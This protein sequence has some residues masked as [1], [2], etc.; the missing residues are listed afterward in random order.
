M[1]SV[2]KY[3]IPIA[4]AVLAWGF[5]VSPYFKE[6]SFGV[7]LFLFGML[8]LEDGFRSFTGGVLE[9]LL[10]KTTS[11]QWKC[12]AFGAVS[13][14]LMQ[15]S[16]LVSVVTMSFL[17]S[18]LLGLAQGMGITLGANIG[19]TT[20][21]WI[22]ASLGMKMNI[23]ALAMPLTIFGIILIIQPGKN[24]KGIGHIL[25]GLG[26][27][28]L[29]MHHIKAGFS[30]FGDKVSL[31]GY[32]MSGFSGLITYVALG[33]AATVLLQSSHASLVIIMAA[34]SAGQ[35]TFENGA[36][37]V[38]GANIGTT[39]TA[40]LGAVGANEQGKRLAAAHVSFNL[41]TALAVIILMPGV[42]FL[43]GELSSVIGIG[44]RDYAMR[45]ALFHT[46]FNFL[47]VIAMTPL[48]G[49]FERL[50]TGWIKTPERGVAKPRYLSLA[51]VDFPDTAVEAVRRE[52][53]SMYDDAVEII[54][55][56]IGF[57][58]SEVLSGADLDGL[59]KA[60]PSVPEYEIDEAYRSRIKEIF[61]AVIEFISKAA[62]SWRESQ[63]QRLFW[64]RDAGRHV[65][66]AVKAAK[67]LQKN[68][69]PYSSSPNAR[70][71]EAYMRLRLE[72]ASMIRELENLRNDEDR[73][74]LLLSLDHLKVTVAEL[75]HKLLDAVYAAINDGS[76]TP[77]MGTSLINDHDYA[78]E[79]IRHLVDAAGTLFMDAGQD[80]TAAQRQVALDRGEIRRMAVDGG[81]AENE[82]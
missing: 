66:E 23:A 82:D 14:T 26:F 49:R 7:A 21:G 27:F 24:Q 63:S 50:L 8:A 52:L 72:V 81:K 55:E 4:F 74:V 60:R 32:A 17:S 28:F 39:S 29:G 22:I 46:V 12:I 43:V 80:M 42:L 36:A 48:I 1:H 16:G 40:I 56:V 67:H 73:E 62:F 25:A 71:A 47:V 58:R 6:I 41:L 5:W 3:T 15:S 76:I 11:S 31:A 34:I 35:I 54:C 13:T 45:L 79:I 2:K 65:S 61:S 59:A 30:G 68:L 51:A 18:N 75:E 70:L 10:A 37:L 19:T 77:A 57:R 53:V 44:A 9:H 78:N 20:G 64:F 38:V 33:T 69:V